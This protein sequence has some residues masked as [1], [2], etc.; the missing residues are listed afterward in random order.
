ML[1]TE[2]NKVA[3]DLLTRMLSN[4]NFWQNVSI[5]AN[6]P[7][8]DIENEISSDVSK[9]SAIRCT[10]ILIRKL[11]ERGDTDEK[12]L[13]YLLN[14]KFFG[15]IREFCNAANIPIPENKIKYIQEKIIVP[16]QMNCKHQDSRIFSQQTIIPEVKRSSSD[17]V[18]RHKRRSTSSLRNDYISSERL[19]MSK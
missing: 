4:L 1:L 7:V 16:I 10:E 11:E 6:I 14:C 5:Q 19:S 2:I 8:N 15:T 17:R 3:I 9:S 12:L 18:I 13:G